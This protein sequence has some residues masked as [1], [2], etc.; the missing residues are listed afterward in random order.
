M[1][2]QEPPRLGQVSAKN[3]FPL[4]SALAI[5]VALTLLGTAIMGWGVFKIFHTAAVFGILVDAKGN[6]IPV[7]GYP[8][9]WI[10]YA[11]TFV[12]SISALVTAVVLAQA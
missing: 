8:E 7:Q 5:F 1:P 3:N 2:L 11:I 4:G 10:G 6:P 12:F 9:L